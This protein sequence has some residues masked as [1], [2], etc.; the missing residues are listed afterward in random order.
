MFEYNNN[1]RGSFKERLMPC[2]LQSFK[3][4]YPFLTH[5]AIITFI[6][7]LLRSNSYYFFCEKSLTAQNVHGCL[8]APEGAVHAVLII[9]SITSF[10]TGLL[11]KSLTLP[12]LF[13]DS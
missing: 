13:N 5:T 6:L 8:L 12:R 9:F 11:L 4:F 1:I 10:S 7:Y 3:I 2:G